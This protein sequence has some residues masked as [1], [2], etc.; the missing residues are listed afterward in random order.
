M[1]FLAGAAHRAIER[2]RRTGRMV[3]PALGAR[4]SRTN[5]LN[6][7]ARIETG[8]QTRLMK[9]LTGGW[10]LEELNVRHAGTGDTT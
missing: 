3:A 5:S 7:M 1:P 10:K 8:Y 6:A 9:A 4:S 2:G